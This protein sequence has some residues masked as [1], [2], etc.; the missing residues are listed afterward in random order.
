MDNIPITEYTISETDVLVDLRDKHLYS[1]GTLK[2]AVSI[3]VDEIEKLYAL[4][5]EKRIVLFCQTGDYSAEIAQL[6][7]DNG[8]QTVN[9]T[10]GYRQY[11]K[12]I[13]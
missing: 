11:L 1:F 2:G 5:K 12:T 9:L 6:L 10:G 8:Y 3:P 4:P 13:L 7:S